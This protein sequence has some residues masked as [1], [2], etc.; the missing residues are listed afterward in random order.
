MGISERKRALRREIKERIKNIPLKEKKLKN[1]LLGN[2]LQAF[3]ENFSQT[4]HHPLNEI[5]LGVFAPLDD[6]A[7]LLAIEKRVS[8]K[9]L[10]FPDIEENQM[11]FRQCPS[12]ELLESKVF[13]VK[14]RT[15]RETTPKVI[16]DIILV[17]GL[18]FSKDGHR[19]GRGKGFYDRY[20]NGFKGVIVGVAFEEQIEADI[21]HEDHDVLVQ[22]VVSECG[23]FECI[24]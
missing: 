17:P 10:A 24:N 6:E 4:S 18:A 1:E 23:I 8:L 5:V 3:L 13:G 16:P 11:I 9:G 21:P 2:H 19:L 14:I 20:L 7:D 12:Q 22:Y 15:P